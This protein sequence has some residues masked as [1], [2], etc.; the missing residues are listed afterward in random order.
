MSAVTNLNEFPLHEISTN[1]STIKLCLLIVGL[2][3]FSLVQILLHRRRISLF[4]RSSEPRDHR[5][6]KKTA[7]ADDDD[8]SVCGGED[9]E[10]IMTRLGFSGQEKLPAKMGAG[11]I[12][13]IF[14]ERE[15]SLGEVREAFDVFDEKRDGFIDEKELQKV[16][17]A[18]GFKEGMEMENCRRMIE[19]VDQDGD[20]RIGFH[21][22]LKFMENTFA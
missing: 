8:E 3:K 2:I 9:V 1:M 11:E 12:F 15:P 5:D 6:T 19:A 16:M 4:F 18:L 17:C 7:A 22:F 10:M 13:Q 21:E 14:E 20:G